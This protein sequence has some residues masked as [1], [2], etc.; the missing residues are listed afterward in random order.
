MRDPRELVYLPLVDHMFWMNY[1]ATG[2]R[3]GETVSSAGPDQADNGYNAFNF[4]KNASMQSIFD[5]GTSLTFVP[6]SLWDDF[7]THF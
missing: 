5:T 4:G 2:V 7:L 1:E 6:H 3:F